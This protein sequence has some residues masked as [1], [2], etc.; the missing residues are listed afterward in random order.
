[1]RA[2]RSSMRPRPS[3]APGDALLR[4]PVL[5][6]R[7]LIPARGSCKGGPRRRPR[8]PGSSPINLVRRGP[9][10]HARPEVRV[11]R[12]DVLEPRVRRV[13]V[14]RRARRP[15]H[16]SPSRCPE[17]QTSSEQCARRRRHL[18]PVS[19]KNLALTAKPILHDADG[20]RRD[21]SFPAD[22]IILG[23]VGVPQRSSDGQP[24]A[25]TAASGSAG[26]SSRRSR[27]SAAGTRASSTTTNARSRHWPSKC[28]TA[29]ITF[30]AGP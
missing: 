5:A 18:L 30:V 15:L 8:P 29:G 2:R 14:R 17:I 24:V 26:S 16:V 4:P 11:E 27:A 7:Q 12:H 9:V 21:Y 1:M 3:R 13:L 22:Q 19:S 28:L 25:L 6:T 20:V 23:P 10:R